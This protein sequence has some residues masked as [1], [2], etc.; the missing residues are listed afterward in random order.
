MVRAAGPLSAAVTALALAGCAAPPRV[1]EV[2]VPVEI[3]GPVR[4]REIPPDLVTCPGRPPP[5]RDG[6]TGGELRAAA[7]GWQ[8]YA[9]CLEGRL[10]EIGGLA[11]G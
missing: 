4:Y 7:R 9:G 11:G 10:A 5:L 1:V 2:R 3:P 8:E 6:M